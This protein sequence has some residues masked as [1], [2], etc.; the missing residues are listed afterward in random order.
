MKPMSPIARPLKTGILCILLRFM[1]LFAGLA[2]TASAQAQSRP[3][4]PLETR[5]V[6]ILNA[7]ESNIPSL[8]KTNQGL[9]A[10]LQSG[11]IGIRNQFYE[12]LDLVRNPGPE[13]R[14]LLLKLLRQRYG[15]RKIDLIITLFP[16]ALNFMLDEGTA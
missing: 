6:L 13:H 1:A 5:N 14:K 12:H 9:S 2:Y 3:Q 11:G 16:E 15:L 10:I 7:F 4:N 8:E